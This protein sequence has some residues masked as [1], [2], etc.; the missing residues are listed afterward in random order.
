MAK[1]WDD[2]SSFLLKMEY[3]TSAHIQLAKV[4]HMAETDIGVV[5]STIHNKDR[6]DSEYFE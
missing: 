6:R 4:R 1:P 5:G 3:I 2:S